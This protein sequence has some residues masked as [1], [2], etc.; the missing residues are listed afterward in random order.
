[1]AELVEEGNFRFPCLSY[2]LPNTLWRAHKVHPIA[3]VQSEYS[4]WT[5]DPDGGVLAT[6]PPTWGSR[7]FHL[8]SRVRL[9]LGHRPGPWKGFPLRISAGDFRRFQDEN[10]ARNLALVDRLSRSWPTREG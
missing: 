8:R 3:A 4:L 2:F 5:R 7:S 10:L 6:C 1:M 9:P